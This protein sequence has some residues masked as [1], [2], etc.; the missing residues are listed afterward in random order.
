MS[1]E[2]MAK[3]LGLLRELQQGAAR[4]AVLVDPKWPLTKPFVSQLRAAALA[5]GQ[6]LIIL[7]VNSDREIENAFTTLVERGAGALI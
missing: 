6:E 7:D 5:V 4:I 3:Q 1:V 2:L